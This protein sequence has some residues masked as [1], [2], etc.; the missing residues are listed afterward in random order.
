MDKNKLVIFSTWQFRCLLYSWT[1]THLQR[2]GCCVHDCNCMG[3]SFFSI[4]KVINQISKTKVQ[5]IFWFYL[6][7]SSFLSQAVLS[8]LQ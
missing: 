3:Y 7:L 5:R 2:N 1:D 6:F 8:G 4:Y